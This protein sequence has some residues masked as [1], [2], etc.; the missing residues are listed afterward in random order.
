MFFHNILKP[1][2]GI[3]RLSRQSLCYIGTRDKHNILGL[4]M[5]AN[6][7]LFS[8]FLGLFVY[9]KSAVA[10]NCTARSIFLN[11]VD[12]SG[13]QNQEL[14]KVDIMINEKG[15]I[16]ITAPQYEV[17]EEDHYLPLS[18][19]LRNESKPEHSALQQLRHNKDLGSEQKKSGS[20]PK[21]PS[22]EIPRASTLKD[23]NQKNSQLTIPSPPDTQPESIPSKMGA[24]TPVQ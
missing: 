13:S 6:K 5:L 8:I 7:L 17:Y 9:G 20:L 12:I 3:A 2:R 21:M 14:K 16:Y 4:C 18:S 22:S 11:G 19:Y 1:L 15:D 23:L 24:K 10:S